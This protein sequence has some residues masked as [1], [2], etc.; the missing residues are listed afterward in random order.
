MPAIPPGCA[1]STAPLPAA[2]MQQIAAENNLAETAFFV[3][4]ADAPAEYDIRW[5]TPAVEI[6]LCGHATLASA[7]VLFTHLGFAGPAGY[8]PQPERPAARDAAKPTAA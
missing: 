7:H 5:F 6:D 4:R 3:P 8:L 1:P 2:L